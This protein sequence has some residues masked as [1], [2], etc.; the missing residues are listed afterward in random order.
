V[1]VGRFQYGCAI[2]FA[3]TLS[4][5]GSRRVRV[6]VLDGSTLLAQRERRLVRALGMKRSKESRT[7]CGLIR[8]GTIVAVDRP[9]EGLEASPSSSKSGS[10]K[11]CGNTH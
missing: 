11:P 7:A 9:D 5:A 8:E 3:G 10:S 2:P 6:A 4:A 1:G